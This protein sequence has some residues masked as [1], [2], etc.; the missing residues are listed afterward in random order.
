MS[1]QEPATYECEMNRNRKY[2]HLKVSPLIA[3]P[4]FLGTNTK[5]LIKAKKYTGQCEPP[6]PATDHTH[7]PGRAD[8]YDRWCCS[9]VNFKLEKKIKNDLL[10][11]RGLQPLLS[12]AMGST[13]LYSGR[14]SPFLMT[15]TSAGW[16]CTVTCHN[17]TLACK[18]T[19]R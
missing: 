18:E 9:D 13:L 14:K 11:P 5:F 4:I 10:E 7:C 16:V 19:G 15:D 1:V 12:V 3:F 17:A 2:S 8:S 6:Q